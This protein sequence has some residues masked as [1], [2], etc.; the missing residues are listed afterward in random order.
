[1]YAP[2]R[3][4]D[5]PR[6]HHATRLSFFLAGFIMAV[7]ASLVPFVKNR[8]AMDEAVFGLLLLSL[9]LGALVTMPAAGMLVARLG[10]RRVLAWAVPATA[11]LGLLIPWVS[12]GW[13]AAAL[14]AFFGAAFGAIDVS[15][16]VHSIEVE[17]ASGRRMLSGFHALYSVGGVAGALGMSLLLNL[18]V[19]PER[20]SAVLFI[21]TALLWTWVGRWTL[22]AG[23]SDFAEGRKFPLPRGRVLILG[24]VC[25]VLFMTEG[26][27]L[28]WGAL[29]LTET[30]GAAI[31]NAG[32][33]FAAFSVA[34]TAMRL[35]G[36]RLIT[37]AGPRATVL[38]GSILASMG[39]V[40]AVSVSSAWVTIL[41]F[42]LVGLG[43]ANIVPIA[44]AG[45]G[46]QTDM[47]MSLAMAGVT[48]LGY[49]G[50]L[51]GPA[52]IG[53]IA[54]HTS[55]GTAFLMEAVLLLAVA[56]SSRYFRAASTISGR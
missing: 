8:L 33:G 53:F 36:D 41:A 26:S 17:K 46:E 39:F 45:T 16:N 12:D 25:F 5:I 18:Q 4:N 48:T 27:V 11:A 50:L 42:F 13:L 15:M 19:T 3:L 21:L 14:L 35:L 40:L 31:E 51:T 30:Q 34:M 20:S 49:A 9:G 43:A 28:D 1:M 54:E 56:W 37:R 55:L 29:Y 32:L 38:I 6:E 52:L 2:V 10:T 44:F 23:K 47:P 24:A 7:W 22:E